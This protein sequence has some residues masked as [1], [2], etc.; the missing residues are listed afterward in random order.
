AYRQK[1][2]DDVAVKIIKENDGSQFDPE[3]VAVFV[4][5]HNKGKLKP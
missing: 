2:P 4:D 3:I 1:M 5:L